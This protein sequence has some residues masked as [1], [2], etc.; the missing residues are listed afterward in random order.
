MPFVVQTKPAVGDTTKKSQIDT[1]IEN[2]QF[3]NSN[4]NA[5]GVASI[6]NGSFEEG[7]GADTAPTNWDLAITAGNSTNFE[8]S[9]ANTAHGKQAF[10]MTNPGSVSGGVTLTNTDFFLVAEEYGMSFK[11]LLKCSIA[12][13]KVTVNVRFFDE[14][15]SFLSAVELYDDDTTNPTAWTN[16]ANSAIPPAGAKL[17]KLEIIGVNN[18]VAASVYIDGIEIV[19]YETGQIK[20][21]TST[22]IPV[23][24]FECDGAEVSRTKYSALFA[25]MGTSFGVGDGSTTFDLPDMRGRAPI[26]VG[27]GPSTT[28]RAM[29][30]SLGV[31]TQ[32]LSVANLPAHTHVERNAQTDGG[33]FEVASLLDADN[34]D[35]IDS[36]INTGSTGSGTAHNN[37]QPSLGVAF[38]VKH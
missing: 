31:E 6:I 28:L 18:T 5:S 36:G 26:G 23:G 9:T 34:T 14:A 29:G 8:T 3:L 17:G 20:M 22:T 32:T 25:V 30:D 21:H 19:E 4:L 16:F 1:L 24:W 10:S 2:D 15:E 33:G 27:D 11:F 12:T 37:M 7:T 38:I 13:T 35:I